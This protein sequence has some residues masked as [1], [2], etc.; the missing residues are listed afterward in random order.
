MGYLTPL[1]WISLCIAGIYYLTGLLADWLRLPP[2][3]WPPAPVEPPACEQCIGLRQ[4]LKRAN[5]ATCLWQRRAEAYRE[6]LPEIHSILC[7]VRDHHLPGWRMNDQGMCPVCVESKLF[8]RVQTLFGSMQFWDDT[9]P[10]QE[11]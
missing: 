7:R 1:I 9:Q 8:E 3:H 10:P 5:D 6:C 4:K 2:A 11:R